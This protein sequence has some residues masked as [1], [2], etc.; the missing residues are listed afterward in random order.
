MEFNID[1]KY[2]DKGLKKLQKKAEELGR[3]KEIPLPELFPD[4][5]IKQYT[6]FQSIQAMVDASGIK[7]LEEIGDEEFSKFVSTHTRFGSW[8]EM[9]KKA[10]SEYIARE[11][12]L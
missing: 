9:Y 11:L 2:D 1:F 6:D 4:A 3:G 8:E 7:N 12:G 10:S 5:F